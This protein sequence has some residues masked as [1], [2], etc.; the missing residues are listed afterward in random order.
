MALMFQMLIGNADREHVAA[1]FF[2]FHGDALGATVI[3]IGSLS[4]VLVQPREVF[5]CALLMNATSLVLAH[6]HPSNIAKASPPDIF[7]TLS[8]V[9]AGDILGVKVVDHLI[10]TPTGGFAS[11]V[12][13][14]LMAGRAG[15]PVVT[16]S[17]L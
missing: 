3:G 12:E 17:N 15:E 6:N 14:G 10:V 1:V 7:T 5:K 13:L 8:L 4:E 2:G 16:R 11:F 9:H